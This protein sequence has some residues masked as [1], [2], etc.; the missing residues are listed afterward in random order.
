LEIRPYQDRSANPWDRIR[1]LRI[2]KS[3]VLIGHSLGGV[4][5]KGAVAQ[6]VNQ[7]RVMQRLNGLFLMAAP[8]LGSLRVP[9]LFKWL[10][11]DFRALAP[12]G[13]YVREI[14]SVF[15]NRLMLEESRTRSGRHNLPTWAVIAVGDIWVDPLSA[16]IGL[17]EE[18]IF[19][20]R[21]KHQEI[22]K[23]RNKSSDSYGYVLPRIV[24]FAHCRGIANREI[25]KWAQHERSAAQPQD[26]S[27]V[28]DFAVRFLGANISPIDQLAEWSKVDRDMISVVNRL[29]AG[30]AKQNTK[31]VAYFCVLKLNEQAAAR[32]RRGELTGLQIT[33]K[34]LTRPGEPCSCI[35]IAGVIGADMIARAIV[36]DHLKTH[37]SDMSLDPKT[38][39]FT[40][41]VTPDGLRLVRQFRMRPLI[42]NSEG[43]R[44]I[45]V[46]SAAE[47]TSNGSR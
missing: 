4:L 23:P 7:K 16:S 29:A 28:H 38:E 20:V 34:D 8:Q 35:Y 26:I 44:S 19:R 5:S 18:Q 9:W 21:G 37:I 6:L 10:S 36:L 24:Q 15:Q 3:I 45:Y 27:A 11:Q 46:G 41:P 13:D 14:D 17:M 1:E 30:G 42:P 31:L 2:Y 12:H 33:A 22:V 39:V 25:E 47:L 43:I 40:R 32:M